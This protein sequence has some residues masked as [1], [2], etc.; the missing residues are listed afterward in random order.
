MGRSWI[1]GY[2]AASSAIAR[3]YNVLTFDAGPVKATHSG[4]KS[5]SSAPIG[6]KVITPVVDYGGDAAGSGSQKNRNTGNQPGWILGSPQARRRLLRKESLRRHRRPWRSRCLHRLDHIPSQTHV[7]TAD[8]RTQN[9]VRHLHGQNTRPAN[10]AKSK[11]PNAPLLAASNS[12]YDTYKAAMQYN[13]KEV[14]AQIQCPMLITEPAN[15]SYLAWPI[16]P[17]L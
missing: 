16:P 3:G 11:L 9:R 8:G 10:Q 1:C 5:F 13:L 6:K 12:Y 14:A 2:G 17:A 4:N 15:E 7:P